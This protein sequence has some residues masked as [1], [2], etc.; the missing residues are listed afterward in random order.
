MSYAV[1]NNTVRESVETNYNAWS[2]ISRTI[3]ILTKRM[4]VNWLE[5]VNIVSILCG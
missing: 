1:E 2:D 3:E 4:L 5:D